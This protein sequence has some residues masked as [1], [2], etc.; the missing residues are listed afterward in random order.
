MF[1]FITFYV[2]NLQ[3]IILNKINLTSLCLTRHFTVITH[4]LKHCII[5][6]NFV[7]TTID[8]ILFE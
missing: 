3:T 6:A 1:M 5:F 2:P 7:F 4:Y 8:I